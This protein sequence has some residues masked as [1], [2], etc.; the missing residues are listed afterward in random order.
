MSRRRYVPFRLSTR[1]AC[2]SHILPRP[3]PGSRPPARPPV[4]RGSRPGRGCADQ[5]G[6][7]LAWA[8]QARQ[9]RSREGS[10][11]SPPSEACCDWTS[12]S[13][14]SLFTLRDFPIHTILGTRTW[15][16]RVHAQLRAAP[17]YRDAKT[18]VWLAGEA[19]ATRCCRSSNGTE[20]LRG[21][22]ARA[23][24]W[25]ATLVAQRAAVG[26]LN[27]VA[28]SHSE[29]RPC[30]RRDAR[31]R[32]APPL[33]KRRPPGRCYRTACRGFQ[34]GAQAIVDRGKTPVEERG[35]GDR[36]SAPPARGRL[37]RPPRPDADLLQRH[38]L[39][40]AAR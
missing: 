36:R 12:R 40:D 22:D 34:G 32:C 7:S 3:S 1:C 13:F 2:R 9:P 39:G 35:R 20:A 23:H 33:G 19:F 30:A 27:T 31:S 5:F 18:V 8:A 6:S 37:P 29:L 25:S 24:A 15:A 11:T 4:P 10:S 14:P 28:H 26:T 38:P 17:E 16:A 21:T